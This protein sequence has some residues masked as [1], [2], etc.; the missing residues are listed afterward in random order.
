M[1]KNEDG[2]N[3]EEW[4]WAFGWIRWIYSLMW[5][6]EIYVWCM[7]MANVLN[8][9]R[10]ETNFICSIFWWINRTAGSLATIFSVYYAAAADVLFDISIF[11][12]ILGSPIWLVERRRIKTGILNIQPIFMHHAHYYSSFA[13]IY[14]NTYTGGRTFKSPSTSSGVRLFLF[15]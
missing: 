1:K 9:W 5:N 2:K 4:N 14:M 6:M 12:C 15:P 10:R 8:D 11:S 7:Y 3:T 13:R